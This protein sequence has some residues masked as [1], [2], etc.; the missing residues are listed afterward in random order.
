MEKDLPKFKYHPNPIKTGAFSTDK[1]VKCDCCSKETDVYYKSP[2]YSIK[3]IDAL[4][5]WCIANGEAA[6]KFD[7][8]FQDMYSCDKVNK[9]EYLDEL[10]HRTPGYRGWQQEYWLSH[11]GDF[12]AFIGYVGW[13][14]IQERRIDKE[15]EKNYSEDNTGFSFDDIK[16]YLG[17]GSMEGYLFKCLKCG[18]HLL[19]VD[20]D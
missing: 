15:I 17:N 5:P 14:D 4:C 10:C 9:K 19:H 20:Y 18:E 1:T 12:C 6:K 2:F 3:N 7:G 16:G 11:C 8:E 13:N